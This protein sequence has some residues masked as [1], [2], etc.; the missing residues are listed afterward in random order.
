MSIYNIFSESV[1]FAQNHEDDAYSVCTQTVYVKFSCFYESCNSNDR[2]WIT[3]KLKQ[4]KSTEV[5]PQYSADGARTPDF[6]QR[7]KFTLLLSCS[8]LEWRGC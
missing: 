1:L 7:S 3:L 5:Q 8:Q 4:Q 6:V 2:L